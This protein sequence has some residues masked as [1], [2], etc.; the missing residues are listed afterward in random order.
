MVIDERQFEI[1]MRRRKKKEDEEYGIRLP[2]RLMSFG[3][4]CQKGQCRREKVT[5]KDEDLKTCACY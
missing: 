5:T 4:R 1:E 3:S 2:V